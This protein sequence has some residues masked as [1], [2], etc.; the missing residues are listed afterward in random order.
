MLRECNGAVFVL[1]W[2]SQ[3][4]W[5]VLQSLSFGNEERCIS[6]TK[7]HVQRNIRQKLS[8]MCV[9][10]HASQRRESCR[11]LE[12]DDKLKM[13]GICVSDSL[14]FNGRSI[15]DIFVS[16]AFGMSRILLSYFIIIHKSPGEIKFGTS[17]SFCCRSSSDV[18]TFLLQVNFF[19]S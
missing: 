15:V 18:Q 3:S 19:L 4:V 14:C 2:K 5:E 11:L 12:L 10:L 6:I 7:K 17:C 1:C 13:I 8:A 16:F 9:A